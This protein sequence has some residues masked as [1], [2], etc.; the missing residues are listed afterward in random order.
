M[1]KIFV[2]TFLIIFALNLFAISKEEFNKI[3]K[4]LEKQAGKYASSPY[5]NSIKNQ[6][7]TTEYQVGDTKVFWKWDLSVMPPTWVQTPSTCR[8]VGEHCYLFVAD[9]DWQINMNESD[10]QVVMNYLENQTMNTNEYGAIEMDIEHF[11]PIPDELDNDPKLIV[12]YSALGSFGGSTFDGYFSVYNQVTEEEAHNLNPPGHSNE[13]EMI[14]M[15][16]Y[17]LDPTDPVRIS[18]LS[19]ELQHLIHWGFDQNE[20]TWLNEGMSELAMVYFGLPDPISQ[21]PSNPNNSLNSWNQTFADYVKTMLFFTYLYEHYGTGNLI[22]DIVEDPQNSIQSIRNQL[23]ENNVDESFEDIFTNWT[24]ANYL[25]NPFVYDSLYYYQSLNLPSFST[26]ATHSSYPASRT[27]TVKA[28]ATKYIKIYSGNSDLQIHF[29]ANHS[30]NITAIKK[31]HNQEDYT[32]NTYSVT[33]TLTQLLPH[34]TQDD[35]YMVLVIS[36][37]NDALLSYSYTIS[38]TGTFSDEDIITPSSNIIAYPNPVNFLQSDLIFKSNTKTS[39]PITVYN[40]KGEKIITIK[41]SVWNGKDK[42]NK[43]VKNGIYLYKTK[44][45][46]TFGKI[47]VIK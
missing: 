7:V 33:D 21:F 18:V 31:A 15:T 29:E 40:L 2:I 44:N 20:D 12:F 38:E 5:H 16:C 14:Y 6:K 43:S 32:V 22:K 36:N 8:A 35:Y 17:P 27:G 1:K 47:V 24:I 10:V 39:Q 4:D 11:G 13:C 30:V 19:H 26:S 37:T 23:T 28:W 9:E 41:N 25:D 45:N 3:E 46:K 34:L 42:N